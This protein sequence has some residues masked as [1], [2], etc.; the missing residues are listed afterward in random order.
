MLVYVVNYDYG[1][2]RRMEAYADFNVVVKAIQ[3]RADNHTK[4]KKLPTMLALKSEFLPSKQNDTWLL[5]M[6]PK[7][8]KDDSKATICGTIKMMELQQ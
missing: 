1:L 3:E 7:Y 4:N 8:D 5:T 2:G 6:H